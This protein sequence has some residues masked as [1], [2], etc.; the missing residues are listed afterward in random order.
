MFNYYAGGVVPYTTLPILVDSGAMSYDADGY[1]V[2]EALRLHPRVWFLS[3][4]V[5]FDDPNARIEKLMNQHGVLLDRTQFR[6]S[7]TSISLSL[8]ALSLPTA[9]LDQIPNRT[10]LLFDSRLRLLGWDAPKEIKS[11]SRGVVK[12]FWQLAEP[13]GEDYGVSLRAVDA[14]GGRIAQR[15]AVPLGN[16][17]GS[18]SWAVGKIVVDPH[19]LPMAT[20]TLPGIYHLQIQVYH[21]ATGNGIGDAII[22]GDVTVR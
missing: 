11:G 4:H 1:A 18:S 3:M 15:D 22:F 13:A 2:G 5:P 9:T 14:S 8:Y 19:D 21:S 7:S 17:A 16:V 10:N 20:G 6:G 12:L